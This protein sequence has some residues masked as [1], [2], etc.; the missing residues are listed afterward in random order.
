MVKKLFSLYYSRL[1]IPISKPFCKHLIRSRLK[2][3]LK[4]STSKLQEGKLSKSTPFSKG[5]T[6]GPVW[7][8][9]FFAILI[10]SMGL[11]GSSFFVVA[12][13]SPQP[14]YGSDIT[15][16][17]G[18]ND[19]FSVQVKPSSPSLFPQ[20]AEDLNTRRTR[21]IKRANNFIESENNKVYVY[22][23]EV[24]AEISEEVDEK[25]NY[26]FSYDPHAD[27]AIQVSVAVGNIEPRIRSIFQN[28]VLVDS[29]SSDWEDRMDGGWF[30][31]ESDDIWTPIQR[32]KIK[33]HWTPE[34]VEYLIQRH[35]YQ[36]EKQA[37]EVA[38][39]SANG[40][41]NQTKQN[42]HNQMDVLQ[43]VVKQ[44][45][46]VLSA[47][48]APLQ[49]VER[50]TLSEY[51]TENVSKVAQKILE[52]KYTPNELALIK[53]PKQIL[54]EDIPYQFQSPAGD[55]LKQNQ[56]LYLKVYN[57]RTPHEIGQN[58][59]ILSLSALEIAD[60]ENALGHTASSHL[61]YQIGEAGSDIALGVTPYVG[62]GKDVYEALTG[63]HLLTGR[64]LT[65]FERTMS[66][67]GIA[68]STVSGGTLSSGTLKTAFSTTGKTLGKI[69]QKALE[70][71]GLFAQKSFETIVDS[72]HKV[73][74][75]LQTAGVRTTEGMKSAGHFL[76]RAFGKD[77]A[78]IEEVA[79]TI[80]FVQKS[81]IEI[82]THSLD[83]LSST[84]ILLPR[85]GE[86]FLARQLRF[87]QK[88]GLE[89]ID[90]THLVKTGKIYSEFFENIDEVQPIS[91]K[92][93][94]WR[95]LK[96]SGANKE[97]QLFSNQPEDLFK[98]VPGAKYTSRRYSIPGEE[99]TY[100]SLSRKT[101]IKEVKA[102]TKGIQ[103]TDR[104]VEE[105]YHIGSKEIEVDKVLDLTKSDTQEL[106]KVGKNTLTEDDIATKIDDVADAYE[107]PQIL[108]HIAKRRGFKAIQAPS[109]PA[110]GGKNLVLFQELK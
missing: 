7:F 46:S 101:A 74:D 21:L 29:Q 50:E 71:G 108:G 70:K 34:R 100:T 4:I 26:L 14:P 32:R 63:R 11:L 19:D 16:E 80:N 73:L 6:R 85:E 67:M 94:A 102:G 104:Q 66:V 62:F 96:K 37:Y 97:G 78:S 98:Q 18:P 91:V 99:A 43:E 39:Q 56:E 27:W 105:W 65:R 12:Q 79:Q 15:H 42:I 51:Y 89:N 54:I 106:F 47:P 110:K 48:H 49:E 88:L 81:G 9:S 25:V 69:H 82:Y 13:N 84:G 2:L 59:K 40:I 55:F 109:A 107:L 31:G 75:S 5:R 8:K 60:E 95:A 76:K 92:E 77:P 45:H 38:F 23:M 61:A 103:L 36:A 52:A 22:S 10:S 53:R 64:S 28:S 24:G 58:A 86:E 1:K 44:S 93:V 87:Q 68:L 17:V 30:W 83:E 33:E 20:N 57:A 72:S 35:T 3:S 41:F 90:Q